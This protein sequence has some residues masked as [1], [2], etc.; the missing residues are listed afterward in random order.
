MRLYRKITKSLVTG[1]GPV[2]LGSS[3]GQAAS[4]ENRINIG[5]AGDME[6]V[7][8]NA[9]KRSLFQDCFKIMPMMG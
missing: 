6:N 4:K 8:Q 5:P 2:C 3:P 9:R 1:F 7:K